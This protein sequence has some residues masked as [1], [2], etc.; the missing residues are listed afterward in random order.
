MCLLWIRSD[1]STAL[2][3]RRTSQLRASRRERDRDGERALAAVSRAAAS[4]DRMPR[5]AWRRPRREWRES[6]LMGAHGND[7]EVGKSMNTKLVL[8]QH[9][10]RHSQH[11]TPPPRA[12]PPQTSRR[13]PAHGRPT[14][15]AQLE[16]RLCSKRNTHLET[17][18]QNR[19]HLR[20]RFGTLI[21]RNSTCEALT[22]PAAQACLHR[23]HP[24]LEL[25]L[26][27]GLGLVYS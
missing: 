12:P 26:G 9:E 27:L 7:S 23:Q 8:T 14:T 22:G 17:R 5:R 25:G 19:R 3:G 1:V 4:R 2:R 6:M 21:E 16:P 13:Q 15:H 18:T 20:T 24:R 11:G 10:I